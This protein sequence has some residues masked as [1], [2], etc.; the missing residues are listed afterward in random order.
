MSFVSLMLLRVNF[1]SIFYCIHK[2]RRQYCTKIFILNVV[3]A[4]GNSK[5][6]AMRPHWVFRKKFQFLLNL[7]VRGE[8]RMRRP[9][10]TAPSICGNSCPVEEEINCQ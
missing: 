4:F 2:H 1:I 5:T 8:V 3:V 10:P 9:L 6:K 7:Q